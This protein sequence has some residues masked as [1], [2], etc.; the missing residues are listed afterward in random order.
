MAHTSRRD[1]LAGLASVLPVALG[2]KAIAFPS[3][4]VEP[5]APA[6]QAGAGAAAPGKLRINPPR[7][8]VMRRG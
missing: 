2:R 7:Q 4:P 5:E 1:L 3:A 6:A 8:S